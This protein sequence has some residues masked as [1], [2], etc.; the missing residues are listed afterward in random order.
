MTMEQANAISSS[1][2]IYRCL[3]ARRSYKRLNKGGTV[4]TRAILTSTYIII[5]KV[6][7]TSSDIVTRRVL[8]QPLPIH[9]HHYYCAMQWQRRV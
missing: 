4:V 8:Y 1:Y 2:R 7:M 9:A 3:K 5:D 6:G